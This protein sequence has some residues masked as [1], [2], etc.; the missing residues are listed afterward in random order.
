MITK[1]TIK[2]YSLAFG[3]FIIIFLPFEISRLY[4]NADMQDA[5]EAVPE[6]QAT[7]DQLRTLS[8]EERKLSLDLVA[9]DR[10]I[11]PA[12]VAGIEANEFALNPAIAPGK[13]NVK[14]LTENDSVPNFAVSIKFISVGGKVFEAEIDKSGLMEIE[15]VSGR[16]YAEIVNKN[17]NYKLKG[18]GPAFFLNANEKKDLGTYYLVKK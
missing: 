8:D 5:M 15:L 6:F 10:K 13:V 17:E 3:I 11:K 1:N 16:Y 2:K 14:I 18:D 12:N 7:E 9:L 4:S